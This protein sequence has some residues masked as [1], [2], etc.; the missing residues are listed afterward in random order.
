[1]ILG[2]LTAVRLLSQFKIEERF[3]FNRST[4]K[5]WI[6]DKIKGALIGVVIGFPFLW[7]L[8]SLVGWLGAWWWI[9]AFAVMMAFQ[10]L[11]MVLYPMIIMPL[12]NKLSPLEEG[13]LKDRL[14]DLSERAGFKAKTIQV[15]DGSKR[16]GHSNAF[17]TGFGKFRRIVLYDTLIDQLSEGNWRQ[18]WP[19]KSA[20]TR[21]AYSENDS[22]FRIDD[23]PGI[24][25]D[26]FS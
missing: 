2:I 19:M 18:C 23:V 8:I 21:R 17:F 14:M 3:G 4:L 11:M 13:S 9:Y 15:I 24:L 22:D 26:H 20:T 6:S 12:F 16:S 25:G 10:L 5:L 7:L 1:M